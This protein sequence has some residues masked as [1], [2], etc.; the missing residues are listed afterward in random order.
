MVQD[1]LTGIVVA[2]W[3]PTYNASR[4]DYN[5]RFSPFT[6]AYIV[7]CQ[8]AMDVIRAI[9]WAVSHK[10]PFRIRSGGHNYEAYSL[11]N[12]GIVI[13]VSAIRHV[14]YDPTTG[15]AKIGS[16]AKLL[17]IY[18]SLWDQ[19]RVT[20][21]GGSCATVGIGGLTLGGG[22]GLV[23]RKFGLTCDSL[24]GLTMVDARGQI[25][26]ASLSRHPDLFWACR[27][28]GGNNFGVVTE[29]RFATH[30]VSEVII[31][32]LQWH[33]RELPKVLHEFQHWSDPISLDDRIV[34]I[35][36]LPAAVNGHVSVVGQFLGGETDELLP[37]LTPLLNIPGMTDKVIRSMSYIEA[38]KHFAG[39]T[40][41]RYRWLAQGVPDHDTFKNTS[42]YTFEI[43]RAP[44]IRVIQDALRNVP[45]P[46]ALVQLDTYGGAI[47]R[48]PNHATAF[49][50][51]KARA[52]LQ[53]QTYWTKPQEADAHIRWVERF[54]RDMLPFT[55]GAYVNYCDSRIERWPK[56]YYGANLDRLLK[57]KRRWDPKNV[58][59]FPQGLSNVVKPPRLC[60]TKGIC[61]S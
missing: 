47:R 54:R 13:D 21:P 40:N 38:V 33:W 2:P 28:G 44:A 39:I 5:T 37:L 53:F 24:V 58:F 7:Y 6:P 46:S 8:K 34:G 26:E 4:I 36:T 55:S 15:V 11:L 45:G 52:C 9:R 49:P 17:D 51:R 35:L 61:G 25:V 3:S 29:F 23:S 16:G 57:V 60:S 20:L 18:E 19:G 1:T 10:F 14:I 30:P 56:A 32:F 41:E 12:A 48:I 42:A 22:F 27:G 50:H 31:F 59:R 43:F